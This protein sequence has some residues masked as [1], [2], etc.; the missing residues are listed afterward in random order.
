MQRKVMIAIAT[1]L[2]S[3]AISLY[4]WNEGNRLFAIMSMIAWVGIVMN[5]AVLACNGWRMPVK[6][7]PT[8]TETIAR[9]TLH[10]PMSSKTK[11]NAL[12]DTIH[13]GHITISAGDILIVGAILI[14]ACITLIQAIPWYISLFTS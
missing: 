9:S 4:A 11:L 7:I 8:N 10:S 13:L 5:L 12:A 1:C 6:E 14:W 3:P 2:L